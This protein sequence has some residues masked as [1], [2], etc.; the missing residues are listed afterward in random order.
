MGNEY[1][2]EFAITPGL[3]TCL[4]LTT[5]S[6]AGGDV[7]VNLRPATQGLVYICLAITAQQDDAA[8]TCQWIHTDGTTPIAVYSATIAASTY[9]YYY[10]NTGCPVPLVITRDRYLIWKVL[11][12]A[13]AKNSYVYAWVHVLKGIRAV[14]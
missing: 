11:S 13:G 5:A 10:P 6:G 7:D 3:P 12:M 8:R 1:T 2:S 4:S 9:A 14:E